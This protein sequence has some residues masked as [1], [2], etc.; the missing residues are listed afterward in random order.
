MKYRYWLLLPLL[1]LL[2]GCDNSGDRVLVAK[3]VY[4]SGLA[5]PRRYDVVV[6]KFPDKPVE[7]GTPKNYIKRLLGLPGE[8]LAIFFGHL[9]NFGGGHKPDGIT[10]EEWRQLTDTSVFKEP[11]DIWKHGAIAK[12][13]PLQAEKVAIVEKLWKAG[14]LKIL[15]KPPDVMLALSRLVY[16]NDHQ[17]ADLIGV[18]PPRW[19]GDRGAAWVA[20][21]Q[22][23]FKCDGKQPLEQ[24]LH[25]RHVKRPAD[26]PRAD[27]PGREEKISKIKSGEH[28][29]QLITDF[30]GYNT[31]ETNNHRGAPAPNWA[32]DLMLECTLAVEEAKGEFWMELSRGIDRFQARFDLATGSCSL[33][34]WSEH[35]MKQAVV[36]GVQREVPD[37]QPLGSAETRVK[38]KGN[39]RLRFANYDERLTVWVD[40]DLPF[41]DGKEYPAP[42]RQGPDFVLDEKTA[43]LD[44]I[45]NN[46]LQPAGLCSMGAAVQ[47]H[48][49][50]LQRD[51]YY[52]SGGSGGG[53]A[54]AVSGDDWGN[55]R[56][57]EPLRQQPV[58]M[59]YVYPGHYMCLGDNSPESSDSRYWGLVPD[60]LMLGR[61]LLV[62]FPF[63]RM[64][65]I[66]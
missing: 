19:D 5:P 12:D 24:W 14:Q 28:W 49:I 59:Y 36:A 7:N 39:Y 52:T 4:D 62:Y 23:G 21:T 34:R 66:H 35:K 25:Y 51:T 42:A 41:G 3:F 13:D 56:A 40:R 46:D 18:L 57:W 20:D 65:T 54:G 26:W 38:G 53:E 32:G 8:I 1:L 11:L 10:E 30:L 63:E 29:P 16:D 44:E 31:Y 60:R 48:N 17:A 9:F 47:V 33:Y 58:K 55:P 6:F 15:R 2:A 45:K 50:K 37:W 22:Q 64:G 61:A 27:S 43:N